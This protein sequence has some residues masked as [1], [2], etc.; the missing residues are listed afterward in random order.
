ML[1]I[2]GTRFVRRVLVKTAASARRTDVYVLLGSLETGVNSECRQVNYSFIITT[3]IVTRGQ[4][5]YERGALASPANGHRGT[6]FAPRLPTVLI[7]LVTSEPHR[8]WRWMIALYCGTAVPTWK[9]IL[10]YG[11]VAVFLHEVGNIFVSP[12]YYFHL[13]SYP[14][15][16]H[17]L[18]TPL[19]LWYIG[20][21]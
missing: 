10:A 17:I 12:P 20:L 11:F 4:L 21:G 8:L 14:S 6:F 2:F 16:Q 5:G 7:I 19:S 1:Q 18:V 9:N 15:L 13:V 3:T